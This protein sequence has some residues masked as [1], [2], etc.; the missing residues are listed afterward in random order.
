MASVF[1]QLLKMKQ[2]RDKA[3]PGVVKKPNSPTPF[4]STKPSTD[5]LFS[6]VSKNP[7]QCLG[8]SC[9]RFRFDGK[10]LCTAG[11]A[12]NVYGILR[13]K[14][15]CPHRLWK[16]CRPE[17]KSTVQCSV[18]SGNRWWRS[19]YRKGPWVCVT[20]HPPILRPHECEYSG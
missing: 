17:E 14:G 18:C 5:L 3:A 20:C 4:P 9:Q 6:A 12:Q 11:P 16:V 13:D 10:P 2:E 7:E 15:Q 8:V 19:R 1:E